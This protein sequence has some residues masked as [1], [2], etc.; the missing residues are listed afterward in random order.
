MEEKL[1]G[2]DRLTA[3]Q[4]VQLANPRSWVASVLP[5]LF[6]AIYCALDGF[7]V[8][9]GRAAA[10]TALCALMQSSV[11]T[12]NDYFDF[13]KG[14]DTRDDCLEESD[15]ILIYQNVDP[16]QVLALGLGY[17]AA[18]GVIGIWVVGTRGMAP[19]FVGAVGAVVVL[20]YSGGPVPI[21]Y[22]PVG[23][24]VSG[25]VM[26]CLI[27]LGAAAGITG[28]FQW[29]ILLFSLPFFLGIALIMM[30]NNASDIEKDN[31]AGRKTLPVLLGRERTRFVYRGL[32]GT[33][34][35]LLCILPV[36]LLG[37]WG[38]VCVPLLFVFARPVFGYLLCAPLIQARRVEQIQ[39]IVEANLKGNGV[40]L[41]T[42]LVGVIVKA[43]NHG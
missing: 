20:A 21:S 17:L 36:V 7:D 40:Y 18:A 2:Y 3:R 28:T 14:T 4:A 6:A 35:A 24:L 37:A 29:K 12:L 11:N 30:T 27:P 1:N 26:G 23:E 5:A 16:R 25:G 42:L 41:L 43:V 8:H 15:A 39:A 31:K 33:W 34:L 13:I 10:L 9:P 38:L 19:L 32:T 22:L